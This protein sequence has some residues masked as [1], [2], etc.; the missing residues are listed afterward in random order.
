MSSDHKKL[1][2]VAMRVRENAYAPYSKFAVGAAV[3]TANGK[4]FTGCNVEN[5]VFNVGVCAERT[6]IFK[7]VS[8]G[9]Q[10]IIRIAVV[11]EGAA[12]CAPCGVCR[13]ALME[14][15]HD[16]VEVIMANTA[17]KIKVRPLSEL[18]PDAFRLKR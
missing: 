14:F 2:E 17:G 4:V 7:A 1:I 3:E 15:A 11:A 6:A 16:D 5:A 9:G 13:Q 10:H 18:L 12:P 8:E